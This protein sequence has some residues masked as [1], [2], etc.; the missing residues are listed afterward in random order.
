MEQDKIPNQ[1][2]IDAH[3]EALDNKGTS[4]KDVDDIWSDVE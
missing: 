4:Y 3:Q 2:T 1:I